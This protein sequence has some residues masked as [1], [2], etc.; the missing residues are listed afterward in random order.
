[1]WYT[2]Y[3]PYQPE[4]SQGRLEAL[5]NYQ[6]LVKR[7]TKMEFANSSLL[8]EASAAGE[9]VLMA[10]RHF[11]NKRQTVIVSENLFESS[12]AVIKTFCN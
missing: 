9:S 6:I 4:I 12:K 10:W 11:R 8:D 5:F 1:M 2:A 7:L 3:T